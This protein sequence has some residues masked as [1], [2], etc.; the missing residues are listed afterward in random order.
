MT[1]GLSMEM[2]NQPQTS[3]DLPLEKNKPVYIGWYLKQS[4]GWTGL[5]TGKKRRIFFRQASRLPPN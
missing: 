4:E 3:D 5:V 2:N 1:H